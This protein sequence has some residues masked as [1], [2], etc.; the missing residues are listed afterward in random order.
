MISFGSNTVQIKQPSS[1]VNVL[2]GCLEYLP[3]NNSLEGSPSSQ[4]QVEHSSKV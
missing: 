1:R 4:R 3:E 2:S